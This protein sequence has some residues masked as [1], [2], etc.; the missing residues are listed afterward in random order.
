MCGAAESRSIW[1]LQESI[2]RVC[3]WS[4]SPVGAPSPDNL[5]LLKIL[6]L[7]A[8]GAPCDLFID[9][10][11]GKT[12]LLRGSMLDV[13]GAHIPVHNL[14]SVVL[15]TRSSTVRLCCSTRMSRESGAYDLHCAEVGPLRTYV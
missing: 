2:T 5:R 12:N 15:N 1:S 7:L 14:L 8:L 13:R 6:S 9:V 4:P 10:V 11:C 3:A